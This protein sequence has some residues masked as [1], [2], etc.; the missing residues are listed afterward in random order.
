MKIAE[1][2]GREVTPAFGDRVALL[3]SSAPQDYREI[4]AL[5]AE[6]WADRR[7]HFVGLAGGQGAGKSTLSALIASA[8]AEVGVRVC[9]LSLDDF[10]Y[11]LSIRRE[12]ASRLH[13]LFETRGPPGTHEMDLCRLLMERLQRDEEVDLPAFDKGI[14]DRVGVR[15]VR[16][17]FDLV[18][19]E[20]WCVGAQPEAESQLDVPINLLE[21]TKDADGRWRRLVHDYLSDSY[22]RTWQMLDYLIFLRVP[23]LEAVRRWRLQ[24]ES[25][26]PRHQ[27]LDSDAI[28]HFV[29]HYERTT[30]AMDRVLP[31]EADLVV[32]LSEDHSVSAMK[33]RSAQS[34]QG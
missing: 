18:L 28:D 29:Q 31:S 22:A 30:L 9:V 21:E 25:G 4:A 6:Q 2:A 23:N 12:R 32:D 24:Q 17:P 19:L 5:L 14:D 34:D 3:D 33:F 20:G 7:P 16:G 11:P 27:R 13:P 1:L 15:S 26:R 8:C 10:Y